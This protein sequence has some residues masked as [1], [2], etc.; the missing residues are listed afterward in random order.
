MK[1]LKKHIVMGIEYSNGRTNS[2]HLAIDSER[3]WIESTIANSSAPKN[4]ES[5]GVEGRVD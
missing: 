3:P 5:E 1:D 2:A 4:L